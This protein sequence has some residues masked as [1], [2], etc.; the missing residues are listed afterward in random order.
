MWGAGSDGAS[1][2]RNLALIDRICA[3]LGDWPEPDW[4][5]SS[6]FASNQPPRH[7]GAVEREDSSSAKP[8]SARTRRRARPLAGDPLRHPSDHYF[9]K[10]LEVVS[11]S[12]LPRCNEWAAALGSSYG[13]LT[14]Q[15]WS[16]EQS[17]VDVLAEV[18]V[19]EAPVADW[20][21]RVSPRVL[22]SQQGDT[23]PGSTLALRQVADPLAAFN[24]KLFSMLSGKH[25]LVC[26]DRLDDGSILVR[27]GTRRVQK[28]VRY[29]RVRVLDRSVRREVA[30]HE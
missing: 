30:R 4:S 9:S 7:A 19:I 18:G 10:A 17:P 6:S 14:T 20:T 2:A 29:R 21:E 8:A 15:D 1:T 22:K 5:M 26:G 23:A 13:A 27:D 28:Q 11:D 25:W 12:L 24:G 3:L 16:T